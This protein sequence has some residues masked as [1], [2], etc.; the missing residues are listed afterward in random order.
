MNTTTKLTEKELTELKRDADWQRRLLKRLKDEG[1]NHAPVE[2]LDALQ[3]V[4][5]QLDEAREIQRTVNPVSDEK[6]KTLEDAVAKEAY[7]TQAISRLMAETKKRVEQEERRALENET[8][9]FRP[10]K[11]AMAQADEE[12]RKALAVIAIAL[13]KRW[14]AMHRLSDASGLMEELSTRHLPQRRLKMPPSWPRPFLTGHLRG[15]DEFAGVFFGR[16][17]AI[18]RNGDGD[19]EGEELARRVYDRFS[20]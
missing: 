19:I 15:F 5:K 10:H 18:F 9:I 3:D 1:F 14:K 8:E 6:Q 4:F 2:E 20:T 12:I 13:R 17:S 16:V 11:E 7:L